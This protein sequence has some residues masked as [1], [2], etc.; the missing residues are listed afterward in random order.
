MEEIGS[1]N[2]EQ[3]FWYMFSQWA[4]AAGTIVVAIVAL[5]GHIIR[6]RW[7]GPAVWGHVR[8]GHLQRHRS[9]R[10]RRAPT[11]GDADDADLG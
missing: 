6:A 11:D 2:N 8:G 4:V 3:F 1:M 7:F 5:W 10:R 9:D